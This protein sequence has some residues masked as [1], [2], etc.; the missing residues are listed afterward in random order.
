MAI[1]SEGSRQRLQGGLIGAFIEHN[2]T[3][4]RVSALMEAVE[5]AIKACCNDF[6]GVLHRVIG[7][8]SVSPDGGCKHSHSSPID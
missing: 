8:D 3:S 2:K 4:L 6:E 7:A 1:S 5:H